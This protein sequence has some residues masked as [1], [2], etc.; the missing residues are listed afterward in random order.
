MVYYRILNIVTCAIQQVLAV[1]LIYSSVFL[2]IL[3]S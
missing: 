2:L 1:Y 3:N